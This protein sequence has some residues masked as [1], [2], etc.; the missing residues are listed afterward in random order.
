MFVLG[1]TLAATGY[2]QAQNGNAGIPGT[3]TDPLVTQSYVN[4][5]FASLE[6]QLTELETKI[7]QLPP[8]QPP[9]QTPQPSEIQVVIDGQAVS[10]PDQKPYIDSAT[11]RMLVPIGPV[12]R[13]VGAQADWSQ[14][15]QKAVIVKD[16]QEIILWIGQKGARVNG[17]T[18]SID[19]PA[20]LVNNRT[21]VLQRSAGV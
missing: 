3:E 19:Q 14:G 1:L 10:F 15:E 11:D 6:N 2:S 20:V 7:D 18:V 13:Q 8:R 21:M 5:L 9:T 12:M 16:G 4:Q 17:K